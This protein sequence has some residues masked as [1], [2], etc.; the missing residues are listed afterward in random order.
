[1]G[2]LVKKHF[3]RSVLLVAG[4]DARDCDMRWSQR[5]VGACPVRIFG[6]VGTNGSC[7]PVCS[8]YRHQLLSQSIAVLGDERLNGLYPNTIPA[9]VL[10]PPAIPVDRRHGIQNGSQ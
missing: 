8:I 3:E 4:V 1:M 2:S 5:G 9:V 6:N 7:G 10:R